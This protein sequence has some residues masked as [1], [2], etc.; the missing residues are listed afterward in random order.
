MINT[1]LETLIGNKFHKK[2]GETEREREDTNDK[3]EV[4]CEHF[5]GVKYVGLFFS[6]AWCV[7][8]EQMLKTLKNF[9]TDSNLETK[10]FEVVFV[11]NDTRERDDKANERAF[12]EH[13]KK[14]PWLAIPFGDPRIKGLYS[15][16]GII[17]VPALII[18]E[19][20]TGFVIQPSGRK[21][22][23][24]DVKAVFDQWNKLLELKRAKAV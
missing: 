18:V 22:L 21:D 9:Y 11:S 7:P 3:E 12:N 17:G 6:A 1:R 19:A 15:H 13:Y 10:Q 8:C 16:F 5:D 14:M 4:N 20:K 2:R 24:E 23:K